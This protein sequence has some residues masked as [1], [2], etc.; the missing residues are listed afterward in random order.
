MKSWNVEIPIFVRDC[1]RLSLICIFLRKKRCV[2]GSRTLNNDD[3]LLVVGNS[4]CWT[5]ETESESKDSM[6]LGNRCFFSSVSIGMPLWN[7][8]SHNQFSRKNLQRSVVLRLTDA[9]GHTV[10]EKKSTLHPAMEVALD[11]GLNLPPLQDQVLKKPKRVM[12]L[13]R[14]KE[15]I[16][17]CRVE[18][19]N[20][21]V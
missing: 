10:R 2:R 15:G 16:D 21:A 6:F 7:A 19:H 13:Y 20:I 1:L 14:V 18:K 3:Q 9:S 5:C 4:F 17:K 11:C 12:R 8:T